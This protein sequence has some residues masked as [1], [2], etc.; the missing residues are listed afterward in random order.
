M[1]WLWRFVS[2]RPG[3]KTSGQ[4]NIDENKLL[5]HAIG[6]QTRIMV[7]EYKD[8]GELQ[9]CAEVANK[10]LLQ[11]TH[12][13]SKQIMKESGLDFNRLKFDVAFYQGI[14]EGK[15]DGSLSPDD[16]YKTIKEYMEPS[17]EDVGY[18][19][20]FRLKVKKIKPK[21]SRWRS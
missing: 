13:K 16:I 12:Q 15:I 21:A 4:L 3:S 20:W 18:G 2:W 14:Q 8:A 11:Q 5:D 9:S 1:S 10:L 17:R 19:M 6:G 7:K